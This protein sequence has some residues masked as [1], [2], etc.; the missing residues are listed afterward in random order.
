[1][2]RAFQT[3]TSILDRK[4]KV[5]IQTHDFPDHD[6]VGSA[7]G[8]CELLLRMDYSCFITYGG[9]LQ[10]ISLSQMIEKLEIHMTPLEELDNSQEYQTIVVDGSP[11]LGTVKTLAGKLVG[12]ID[13]HPVRKKTTAPFVDIRPEVGSCSSIIWT[14]WNEAGEI[15]DRTTSTAL[16]AGI[17]LDTASL[18]RRVSKTDLDAHYHLYFTGDSYLAQQFISVSLSITQLPDIA[19]AMQFYHRKNTIL[20]LEVHGDY[21]N[22]LLS[23]LANF[24]LQLREITFAVVLEKEGPEYRL[25]ARSREKDIDTGYVICNALKNMGT[26]GGHPEMAGGVI[27]A[28]DYPGANKFL[29]LIAQEVAAYKEGNDN[30][31]NSKTHTC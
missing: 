6:A 10:S 12:I 4:K 21:P 5:L 30:E 18:S 1:M 26:G 14:Y 20:F 3:L 24:L 28:K 9:P 2:E 7:Y 19:R 23:V 27:R 11:A 31:T 13:H 25:S 17:K 22:E 29:K 15:P 8:L 16:L